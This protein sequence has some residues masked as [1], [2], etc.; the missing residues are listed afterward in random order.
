MSTNPNRQPKGTSVGGQFAP[1]KNPESNVD[2]DQPTEIRPDGTRLWILNGELHRED[3]PPPAKE[4][5]WDVEYQ[6]GDGFPHGFVKARD[7][8]DAIAKVMVKENLHQRDIVGVTESKESLGEIFHRQIWPDGETLRVARGHEFVTAS[9]LEDIP[10]LYATENT[11]LAEKTVH[12]HYFSAAADWYITELDKE[13]GLAFG[14]CDLGMGFPE[15]GYVDLKELEEVASQFG[16]AVVERD[17]HFEPML[18]SSIDAIT[19]GR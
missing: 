9:M 8:N 12:A 18:A 3:G 6:D 7:Q 13:E 11:S 2:L 1:D 16:F 4:R 19:R 14:H 5:T 15:W 10:D 17:V